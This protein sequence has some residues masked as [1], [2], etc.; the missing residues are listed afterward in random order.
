MRYQRM[1][2]TGRS[3]FPVLGQVYLSR[4][5]GLALATTKAGCV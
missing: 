5:F 4:L 2:A 1:L 3:C